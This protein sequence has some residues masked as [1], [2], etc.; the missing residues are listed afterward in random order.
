MNKLSL[1]LA[2][3]QASPYFWVIR[4]RST[5]RYN[6]TTDRSEYVTRR[7]AQKYV[8]ATQFYIEG[9]D[10]TEVLAKI[11]AHEGERSQRGINDPHQ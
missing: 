5:P 11:N 7:I 3:A 2:Q 10:D 9:A 8:G 4:D 1:S 6:R